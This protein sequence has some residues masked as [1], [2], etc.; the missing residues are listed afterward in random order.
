MT[1][2]PPPDLADI[3]L[4]AIYPVDDAHREVAGRRCGS[5]QGEVP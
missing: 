3:I 4:D 1:A 2:T 5:F